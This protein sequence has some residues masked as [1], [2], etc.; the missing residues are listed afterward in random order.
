[1][2]PLYELATG[3]T[4][5]QSMAWDAATRSLVASGECAYVDRLGGYCGYGS[6][7]GYMWPRCFHKPSD[8]SHVWDVT[9]H[10][11]LRYRFCDAPD[12]VEVPSEAQEDFYCDPDNV[13][14]SWKPHPGNK[15]NE[16]VIC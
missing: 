4:W 16:C 7:Q 9:R 10:A 15:D 3:N 2:R 8:F 14:Q 11:I 1:M 6:M 12:L 5:V 13:N